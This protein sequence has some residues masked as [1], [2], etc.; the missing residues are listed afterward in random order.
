MSKMLM[1]ISLVYSTYGITSG[2]KSLSRA[3]NGGHF[4]NFEIVNTASI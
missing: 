4:E 1:A 3:Q 2:K